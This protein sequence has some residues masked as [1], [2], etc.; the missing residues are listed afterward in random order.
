MKFSS[1]YGVISSFPRKKQL[2]CNYSDDD[3]DYRAIKLTKF[4]QTVIKSLPP[5]FSLLLPTSQS[6][7]LAA[8]FG[9]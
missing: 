5:P 7:L 8:S 1:I 6:S 4:A 9:A 3:D 2:W